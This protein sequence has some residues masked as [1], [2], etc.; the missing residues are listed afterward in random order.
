MTEE[1]GRFPDEMGSMMRMLSGE[2]VQRAAD[3]LLEAAADHGA[4]DEAAAMYFEARR[5]SIGSGTNEI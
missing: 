2:A 4:A 3:L 5:A 1:A